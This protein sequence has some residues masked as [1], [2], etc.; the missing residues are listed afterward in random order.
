ML[1]ALLLAL[2]LAPT[3][4][5]LDFLTGAW[6]E[7]REGPRGVTRFEEH[8]L[9]A[10]G[11]LMLGLG[12]TTR[13]AAPPGTDERRL[14]FEFLRIEFRADGVVYVA[15]PNGRPPTEFRLTEHQPGSVLFENPAH[16]HPQR[17]RYRQLEGGGLEAQIEGTQGVQ[18]WRFSRPR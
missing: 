4:A 18:R 13:E 1:N 14:G 6:E 11:G 16:D 3:P 7:R 2:A 12:R 5:D 10:R 17:I 9:P 8:W 15:Q